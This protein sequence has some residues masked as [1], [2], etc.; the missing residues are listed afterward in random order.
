[1]PLHTG[2]V[3]KQTRKMSAA[4]QTDRISKQAVPAEEKKLV[5]A[6]RRSSEASK[7]EH[8]VVYSKAS[9]QVQL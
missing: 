3:Q 8:T 7:E 2:L 5:A 6:R 4:R 1:M 9:Q